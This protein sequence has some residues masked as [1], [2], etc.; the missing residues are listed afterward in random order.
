V[1]AGPNI[2]KRQPDPNLC[3][4]I[5]Q[6]RLWFGQLASGE[7]ASI[8]A[9]GQLDGVHETEITRNLPLAFLASEIIETIQDGRQS[10]GLSMKKPQAPLSSAERLENP[11]HSAPKPRQ[12]LRIS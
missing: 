12:D 10:E 7:A 11:G 5:V 8:R 6:A 9:I 2:D 1:I 4:L 3:S